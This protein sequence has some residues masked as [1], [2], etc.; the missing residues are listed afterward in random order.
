MLKR[1]DFPDWLRVQWAFSDFG[2]V[3][4]VKEN[5]SRFRYQASD[6]HDSKIDAKPFDSIISRRSRDKNIACAHINKH[7]PTL[8]IHENW[9]NGLSLLRSKC[10]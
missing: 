10:T 3:L 8:C 4:L 7:I 2:G 1:R 5:Y 9:S 6:R